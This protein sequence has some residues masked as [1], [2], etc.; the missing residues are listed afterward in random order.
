MQVFIG[1]DH[2]GFKLKEHLKKFLAKKGYSVKDLG[3]KKLD[4]KDDYP[5]FAYRVAKAVSKS[6][7]KGED[8]G[9][10]CC[11]SAEGMC[12]AANKVKG[13]RAVAVW[14][15]QNAKLSRQHNDANVLC[16]GGWQLGKAKAEKIVLAWL[17]T[18]F[19]GI[20]RHKRRIKKIS[21]I[22]RKR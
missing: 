12:I 7:G 11:G 10:L 6:K 16:L 3:N 14:S 18:K 9:V 15:L 21:A 20:A 8:K 1:A 22:E 19:S 13:V 2:A 5:D 17:K 4:S